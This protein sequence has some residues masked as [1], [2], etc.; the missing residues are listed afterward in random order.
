MGSTVS[1]TSITLSILSVIAIFLGLGYNHKLRCE[2]TPR[3]IRT[4]MAA[5][6]EI[7]TQSFSSSLAARETSGFSVLGLA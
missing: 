5:P 3:R 2:F 1:R 4:K 6:Q 7:M